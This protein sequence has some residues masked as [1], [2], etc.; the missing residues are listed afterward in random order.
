[1]DPVISVQNK[2]ILR[3]TRSLQW[4]LEPDRKPEVIFTLTIQWNFANAQSKRRHLCGFVAIR[5]DENWWA[6]SMEWCET[7]GTQVA[8]W[9]VVAVEVGGRWSDETAQFM[10]LLAKSRSECSCTDK[11]P[12]ESG[13]APTM[14]SIFGAYRCACVYSV[15][16]STVKRSRH[17]RGPPSK[18]EVLRDSRLF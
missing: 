8:R 3:K 4:F 13:M 7:Y 18:Q 1:M 17:R 5:S 6:D 10:H 16:V 15:S 9:A 14:G 2:K 11:K 12:L